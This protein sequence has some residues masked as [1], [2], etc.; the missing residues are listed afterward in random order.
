MRTQSEILAEK[1]NAEISTPDYIGLAVKAV[2]AAASLLSGTA[3]FAGGYVAA[4]ILDV[5]PAAAPSAGAAPDALWMVVPLL[6]VALLIGKGNRGQSNPTKPDGGSCFLEGTLI[7]TPH[8]FVPVEQ[9]KPGMA[10]KSS[11]GDQT[12]ICVTSWQP[13]NPEDRAYSM[14]GVHLS[15]NHRVLHNGR[16]VEARATSSVRRMLDGT[17]YHHILLVD[18]S[19]L[20][21]SSGDTSKVVRAE[22]MALTP[23][24]PLG[25]LMPDLAAHHAAHPAWEGMA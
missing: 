21:A 8:G 12:I 25:R 4:P 15:P 13:I 10:V 18:H 11:K 3:A 23:D 6:I 1:C 22:S 9:L 16:V 20:Y 17:T 5:P 7:S 24:M 19:W 2:T 14:D